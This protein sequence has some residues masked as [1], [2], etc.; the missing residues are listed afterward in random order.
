MALCVAIALHLP[1]AAYAFGERKPAQDEACDLARAPLV[2]C[3]VY[4]DYIAADRA[5]NRSY[6]T[7]SSSLPRKPAA[8]LLQAQRE[9]IRFRD[10]TCAE[11]QER[12]GC[13]HASCD[14][15]EH[16]HCVLEL[17]EKR[18]QELNKFLQRLDIGVAENF[19]FRTEYPP[20]GPY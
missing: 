9:W 16:D 12:S 6:R 15:V 14:G 3:D 18:T 13:N 8:I 20:S 17:T 7:L 5:L 19:R 11:M 1:S 10:K 2:K 4:P